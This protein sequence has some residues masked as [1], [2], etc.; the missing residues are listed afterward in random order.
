MKVKIA[1]EISSL[2]MKKEN[3]EN[4]IWLRSDSRKSSKVLLC[5]DSAKRYGGV[6]IWIKVIEI[7][8]CRPNGIDALCVISSSCF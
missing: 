6:V 1:C 3:S 4:Y 7:K 5:N 8:A 2:F